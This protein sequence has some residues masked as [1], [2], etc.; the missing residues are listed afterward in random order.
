MTVEE[1]PGKMTSNR[2]KAEARRR[3]ILAKQKDRMSAVNGAPSLSNPR[4]AST[5]EASVSV[6]T[7]TSDATIPPSSSA[8]TILTS[9]TSS[10][11]DTVDA[12]DITADYHSTRG[13]NEATIITLG[14]DGVGA[15]PGPKASI[16]SPGSSR[17]AQ[18]RRRRFKK[19]TIESKTTAID[20][21]ASDENAQKDS[22]T[23]DS[24]T[25]QLTMDFTET[26]NKTEGTFATD[27]DEDAAETKSGKKYLGVVR[28]RRK[29]L[30]EQKASEPNTE[31]SSSKSTQHVQKS[32]LDKKSK[33][34]PLAPILLE[35]FTVLCL[36]IV[37]LHTGIQS[38]KSNQPVDISTIISENIDVNTKYDSSFSFTETGVGIFSLFGDSK[39]HKEPPNAILNLVDNDLLL[40]QDDEFT[41]PSDS[42]SPNGATS[43][44]KRSNI[45]PL[46]RIDLDEIVRGKTGIVFSAARLA[47]QIHRQLLYLLFTLPTVFVQNIWS[48]PQTLMS[49]PPILFLCALIIRYIGKHIFGA[50]TPD[51]DILLD[52]EIEMGGELSNGASTGATSMVDGDFLSMGKNFVLNFMKTTFPN[53]CM[54]CTMLK[55]VRSDMYIILCGLL[56][57]SVLP[58]TLLCETATAAIEEL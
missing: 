8:A 4:S 11:E 45:D 50:S 26:G 22:T 47:I 38:G 1:I 58:V 40:E 39:D 33:L 12:E 49:N 44:N 3:R 29:M 25:G 43:S 18:M 6:P 16:V 19:T 30:A 51:W 31:D 32:S 5:S 21:V 48:F 2:Q 34:V 23:T 57:G 41:M 53:L 13:D 56:L 28:M 20:A 7:E 24:S 37:G 42:F 35:F 36:F 54:I 55:D 27:D 9:N 52:S 14:T 17:L 15:K 46:F 10:Q